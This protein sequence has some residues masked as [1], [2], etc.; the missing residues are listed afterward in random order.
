MTLEARQVESFLS[1]PGAARAVLLFGD[2]AGLIR[3]RAERLVRLVAGEVDDPFRVV[4]LDS[5]PEIGAELA[6]VPLSGGRRVVRIRAA[7]DGLAAFVRTALEARSGGFLVME[8]PGLPARSKLRLLVEQSADSVAIGCYPPDRRA[9][10]GMIRRLLE[11]AGTGADAEAI[12]WLASHLG[13][14]QTVTESEIGKLSLYVGRGGHVDVTVARSCVGDLAGLSID[15]ALFAATAADLAGVDRALDL[16][17]AEG[18]TPVG[19]LRQTM[20]HLHRLA[21][22]A[23][24]VA[25]GTDVSAAVRGARPP[26]FYRQQDAFTRAIRL[27]RPETLAWAVAICWEAEQG[28]KRTGAPADAICR[29]TLAR[30]ARRAA[31]LAAPRETTRRV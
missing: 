5:G 1:N 21:R 2:D 22:V 31:A 29:F 20:G 23:L 13:A 4:D 12:T 17:L 14:D 16:A 25:A 8:A 10:E 26:V 28:C 27:W 18:G 15:D 9:A 19:I 24:A 11:Q 6:S 3:S 7:G 30:I